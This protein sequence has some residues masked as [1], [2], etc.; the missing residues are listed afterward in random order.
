MERLP[1]PSEAPQ[2]GRTDVADG[3][4]Y[5]LKCERKIRVIAARSAEAE[6]GI[7]ELE[8]TDYSVKSRGGEYR[9]RALGLINIA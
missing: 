4:S 2:I 1:V 5:R 7:S 9:R 8:G 3:L 6:E